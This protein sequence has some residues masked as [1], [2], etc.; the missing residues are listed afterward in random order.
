MPIT[1]ATFLKSKLLDT[2]RSYRAYAKVDVT[3]PKGTVLAS[4]ECLVDTGSDYTILPQ[5]T[6]AIAGLKLTGPK[7]T[8][9]TAGGMSYSLPSHM[10]VHLLVEGYAI[11]A[12][13]LF[14]SAKSFLPILGRWEL[15]NAFDFGFDDTNWY[16]G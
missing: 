1:P 7:V 9:R 6:A 12:Q 13:V 8:F 5:N 15:V 10:S 4:N 3:D 11:T 2:A 14:S 16:W